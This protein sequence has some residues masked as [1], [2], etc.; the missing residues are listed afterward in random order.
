MKPRAISCIDCGAVRVSCSKG[1]R[2]NPCATA[3]KYDESRNKIKKALED[4]G[5]TDVTLNGFNKSGQ[6]SFR[7]FHSVCGT[8]QVWSSTNLQKRLKEDPNTAPC[9][10]CGSKRRTV[11]ATR[12]SALNNGVPDHLLTAWEAYRR[13]TRR[14]TERTYRLHKTTINPLDLPRGMTSYHLDHKFPIIEGFL[15]G[16]PPE[17]IARAENLHLITS[18]QNLSKGRQLWI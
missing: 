9:S 6:M 11:E 13:R 8:E 14:L 2:C 10:H 1:T 15:Q 16:H 5:H 3:L 17:F 18:T 12:V 7:F 4:L